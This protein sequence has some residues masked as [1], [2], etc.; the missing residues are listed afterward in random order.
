MN[1]L[2]M[3]YDFSGS[4]GWAII[5][6]TI[7]VKAVLYPL[8]AKQFKSMHE[9]KKIQPEVKK[10]QAKL[11]DKPEE[12]QKQ[13]IALY[14]EHGVNPLGGC[15][16]LLV[17]FPIIIALFATLRSEAFIN[18][19]G[20]KSFL[21][22]ANLSEPDTMMIGTLSIPLMALIV[23][24][25]TYASQAVMTMDPEQ[26]KMMAFMPFMLFFISIKM[27]AGVLVYWSVS[28][29]LTAVQQS[30]METTA[31]TKEKQTPK[32]SIDTKQIAS[33]TTAKKGKKKKK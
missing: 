24:I 33:K 13:L 6:L 3:F 28:N 17:Q 14:K 19:P 1:L 15:L 31:T 8:S 32:K 22:I 4:Y 2:K 10:L 9:M 25:T 7:F 21:W 18:L 29:L 23:G 5:L 16:P 12:M 30:L 26:K 11:K 27:H 20:D